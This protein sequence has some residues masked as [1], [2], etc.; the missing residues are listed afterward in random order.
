MTSER[1]VPFSVRR[2]GGETDSSALYEDL[3][4]W[5]ENAVSDW[6]KAALSDYRGHTDTEIVQILRL[7]LRQTIVDYWEPGIVVKDILDKGLAWDVADLLLRIS[8]KRECRPDKLEILLRLSGSAWTIG[9]ANGGKALVS[10]VSEGVQAAAAEAFKV[11]GAGP[12]LAKAWAALYGRSPDPVVAYTHAV[13]AIEHVAIP[14]VTPKDGKGTL[15]KVATAL[16]G[17]K[18]WYMPMTKASP[19]ATHDL[20]AAMCSLLPDGH[21][22]RH[23]GDKHG[24]VSQQDAEVAVG[25]AVTLVH[26]FSRGVVQ[27]SKADR[28]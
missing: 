17:G 13:K 6:L 10:R 5:Q 8:D 14:T 23:G 19:E 28:A 15:G 1:F 25:L 24:D 22:G 16:R 12:E 3:M 7:T 2:R 9:E 21:A 18:H 4:P 26:W 27:S 11:E 20:V